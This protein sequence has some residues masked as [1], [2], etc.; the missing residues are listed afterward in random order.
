MAAAP[1][2][3]ACVVGGADWTLLLLFFF[4][5]SSALSRWR[6]DARNALVA[7]IV[8]KGGA[9]DAVQVL[10]NGAVVAVAALAESLAPGQGWQAI[11]AG[12]VASA[13]S[14]TWGTEIGTVAGGT[15]RHVITGAAL[16]PG[17]SGGVT[18]AGSGASLLG[19]LATSVVVMAVQ[20]PIPAAA[21]VAGGVA[22]AVTDSLLGA[23]V[24]ERRW[25]EACGKSTERRVHTCGAP[26]TRRGGLAGFG[27]DAVNLTSI[28]TGAITARVLA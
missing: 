20:W 16:L 2:G 23:T 1:V 17:T 18:V 6:G 12:A 24:Q 11:G 7:G 14:D 28:V 21:V 5:T 26:T 25:C 13:V 22:G 4:S 8:E 19:A 27:N 3:A 10:A 15:P 9:R